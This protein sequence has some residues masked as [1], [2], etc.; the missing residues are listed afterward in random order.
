[1]GGHLG[2]LGGWLICGLV[3][4]GLR[5]RAFVGAPRRVMPSGERE[6]DELDGEVIVCDFHNWETSTE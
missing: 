1:M 5:V 6:Y 2:G 3:G 4:L